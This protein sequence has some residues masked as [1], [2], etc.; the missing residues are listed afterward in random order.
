MISII[1]GCSDHASQ[2]TVSSETFTPVY[3]YFPLSA[4][5]STDYTITNNLNHTT[6]HL[7]CTMGGTVS[8]NDPGSV[9]WVTQYEEYPSIQDTGY[10]QLE[11]DAV[12]YYENGIDAPEK[13]L[14]GPLTV[15]KSWQRY[16]PAEQHTDTNNL[17]YIFNDHDFSFKGDSGTAGTDETNRDENEMKHS[18][19]AKNYPTT[20]ANYFII[21]GIEDVTLGEGNVYYGCVKVENRSG[22]YTNYYWYAPEVGLVK[23][24]NNIKPGEYPDGQVSGVITGKRPF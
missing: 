9:L 18:G 20:G 6:S 17:I 3:K 22:E 4:G 8:R 23:F 21:S 2:I 5:G 12:Y 7:R 10:F 16:A 19:A 11:G 24:A 13:I 15:G 1:S 14:E